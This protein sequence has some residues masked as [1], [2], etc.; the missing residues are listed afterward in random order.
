MKVAI[1]GFGSIGHERYNALLQLQQ[2]GL[3]FEKIGIY[4]P[5]YIGNFENFRYN[6]LQEVEQFN[7]DWVIV[8]TPHDVAVKIVKIASKWNCRILMEKPFGRNYKEALELYNLLRDD[9]QLY[10]GF[11]Y[12][13]FDGIEMFY[14]HYQ[15]GIFGD[16]VSIDLELGHGGSPQNRN[17]WVS[18]PIKN[19]GVLID[20]TIHLFH[21][22]LHFK[23]NPI[24]LQ[25]KTWK[26]FWN[27]GIDEEVHLLLE[28]EKTIINIKSSLVKWKSKFS[29][30]IN[31][32]DK[33]GIITGRG[34][35]YGTQEYRVGK[36]WGWLNGNP[37]NSTEHIMCVTDCSNSF[38]KE[39]KNLF[40]GNQNNKNCNALMALNTMKFY[41][42]CLKVVR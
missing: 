33:Y 6:S 5:Y 10:V 17:S 41:D 21:L 24:P 32:T 39:L 26:G 15:A 8:C 27:T 18:D 22:L 28:S 3:N 19:G 42:E 34:K 40:N 25:G 1:I 11:N 35:S 23:L 30:E 12:P 37:Q 36:R 29:F 38:Y 2:E 7:P 31:G 4:D 16:I 13:F 9:N 14:E 20:P